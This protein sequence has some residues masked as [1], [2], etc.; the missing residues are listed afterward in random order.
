MSWPAL[1][2]RERDIVE[3][4]RSTG[5]V[6][7]D[8]LAQRFSVTPQTI[9]R[10]V[11]QL[12]EL[13]LLR[14]VH[15]GVDVPGGHG[16]LPYQRRQVLNLAAKQ[17]IASAVAAFIPDGAS[18]SIGLGTTPEQVALALR[19]HQGLKVLTNSVNVINALAGA[20]L[21]SLAI[22]GGTLRR[23]D[24]DI[25]GSAAVAFFSAF[26]T[27]YAVFGVGGI[28]RDGSLLDFHPDEVAARQAMAAN[29]RC[30]VLVADAS[31]FGRNA[32]ARGGRL[33][34]MD[35]LFTEHALPG[36]YAEALGC[37]DTTVH[38]AATEGTR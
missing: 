34:D 13:G 24:L 25:V 15:G 36:D 8:T 27:D 12:C 10:S 23:S 1:P 7:I 20:P 38:L 29:S 14:R 2:A 6:A 21:A 22:A 17:R 30:T 9:R 33:G 32:V 11:N 5:H 26:K 37:G 16:N 31:K 28:D 18:V 4:V 35:H 3:L 19:G